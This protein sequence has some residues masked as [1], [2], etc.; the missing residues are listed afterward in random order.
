MPISIRLPVGGDRPGVLDE[1][2]LNYQ[3]SQFREAIK[4]NLKVMVLTMPGEYQH[5][6]EY[7]VGVRKFLFEPYTLQVR[8]TIRERILSQASRY[9]PYI[10]IAKIDFGEGSIDENILN[11][12]I[13]YFIRDATVQQQFDVTIT[14]GTEIEFAVS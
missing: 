1:L 11:L 6:I 13:S 9:M 2:Q 12:R 8:E 7:G 10:S 4:Q 5:D 14:Y 3:D